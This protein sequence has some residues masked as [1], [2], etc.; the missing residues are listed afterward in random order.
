M[1]LAIKL[2]KRDCRNAVAQQA[3]YNELVNIHDSQLAPPN[4]TALFKPTVHEVYNTGGL[5]VA[6]F[7][8]RPYLDQIPPDPFVG[9]AVW[10]VHFASG[11]ATAEY[12][13]G[14]ITHPPAHT[15]IFDI[16]CIS[17][18]NKRRGFTRAIDGTNYSDW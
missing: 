17:D 4:I 9:A 1:R 3:G 6:T 11:T 16:S 13:Q 7:T 12:A 14:V 15:G 8:S 2:F 18:A 5:N 10:L